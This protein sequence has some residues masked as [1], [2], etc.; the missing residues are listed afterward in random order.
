MSKR[1]RLQ[2]TTSPQVG[3]AVTALQWAGL[4]G[5]TRAEVV[6]RLVCAAIEDLIDRGFLD[7]EQLSESKT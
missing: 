5:S 4:H 3:E 6:E 2:C 7:P 1:V